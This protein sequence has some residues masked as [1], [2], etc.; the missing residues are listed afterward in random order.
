MRE[1]GVLVLRAA[2]GRR[3]EGSKV[4]IAAAHLVEFLEEG[5]C[6]LMLDLPGEQMKVRTGCATFP[7]G[8]TCEVIA[9]WHS[10]SPAA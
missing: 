10:H 9:S 2:E 1:E 5:H 3:R 7:T 4:V 6:H 8:E